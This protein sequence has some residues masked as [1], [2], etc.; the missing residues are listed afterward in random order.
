MNTDVEELVRGGM[1][2]LAAVTET[3]SG[4]V[5]RARRRLR[6]RRLAAVSAIAGGAVAVTAVAVAAAGA[7]G[8]VST[9]GWRAQTTAYVVSRVKH[10]LASERLVFVGRTFSNT[11]PSVTWAYGAR[12]RFEEFTGKACGH[13]LPNGACT[14]H[15]GSVPFTAQGTAL[16]H[17]KL[18]GAYVTYFDHRYRLSPVWPSPASACSRTAE[19]GMGGPPVATP[20]WS[21]FID[22][23]LACGAARVTG[24]VQIDGVETTKITGKP[25]T[26]KL[27]PGYG[28]LVHEKWARAWWVLYVNPK[29]YLPVRIY[30]STETF[31]GR[32]S[33]TSSSVTNV[34]W[35]APTRA[36]IARALV[37]IPPGFHRWWGSPG[38]Q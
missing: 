15:G 13:T 2:R 27:S 38:N 4:L 20:R 23:T 33:F 6:R 21:A 3:P 36:N 14:H 29:T 10:A 32:R 7:G 11:G 12:N 5:G 16:V 26:V 9:S 19:L 35:L 1:H 18:R 30:G 37:T 25:V 22:A 31:G 24:H 17:G 34:T 28:K 8:V